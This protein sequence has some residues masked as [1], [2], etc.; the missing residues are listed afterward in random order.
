MSILNKIKSVIANGKQTIIISGNKVT[1]ISNSFN[2]NVVI[3]GDIVSFNGEQ[4]TLTENKV[5][6]TV[7]GNIGNLELSGNSIVTVNGNVE[8][9]VNSATGSITCANVTGNVKASLGNIKCGDVGGNVK[10]SCGN[11]T[12]RKS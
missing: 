9:D 3:K 11:I 4:V 10:A 6:I 8:G 7:D 2:N 5:E 12:M 1:Q